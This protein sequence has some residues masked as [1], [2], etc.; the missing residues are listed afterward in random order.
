MTRS[1]VVRIFTVEG[2]AHSLLALL[3]GAV[4][5]IPFLVYLGTHGIPMPKSA[6]EAGM[7][8]SES[9][10]PVYSMG[11]VASTILLVVVSATIVSYLPARKISK[12]KPTD[13][14]KGKIQ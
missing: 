12:M 14:L 10:M 2:S 11:M 6:G 8:I 3:L 9:I 4:Y 13:A 5:G 1:Q 7:A